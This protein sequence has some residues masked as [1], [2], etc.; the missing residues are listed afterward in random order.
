MA[1][2]S[3]GE[4]IGYLAHQQGRSLRDVA[5]HAE[6]AY[7]TVYSI[8]K[9]K[10]NNVN[11]ETLIK[12]AAALGVRP[13][14][15]RGEAPLLELVALDNHLTNALQL[16]DLGKKEEEPA[17]GSDGAKEKSPVPAQPETGDREM[18]VKTLTEAFV[19][20]GFLDDGGLLSD[21]DFEFLKA[22]V[23][24]IEDHFCK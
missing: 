16:I 17:A 8:V 9:R 24:L 6:V 10:S 22:L 15:L 5:V 19:R 7:N 1:Q 14:E 3:I 2:A 13:S 18:L 11:S 23:L 12:I 20:A 21:S 4:R